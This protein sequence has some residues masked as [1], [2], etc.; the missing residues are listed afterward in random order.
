[1]KKAKVKT[2]K[3]QFVNID[4]KLK[5]YF[6]GKPQLRENNKRK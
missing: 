4:K 6:D 1:M 5:K 2:D 3:R